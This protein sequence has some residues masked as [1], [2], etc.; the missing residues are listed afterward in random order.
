MVVFADFHQSTGGT[1][2]NELKFLE[3]FVGNADEQA[4]TV[5]KPGGDQGMD[6]F[7]CIREGEGWAEFRNVFDMEKAGFVQMFDVVYEGELWVQLH[8]EIGDCGREGN[9]LTGE[10]DGGYE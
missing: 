2:L 9:V 3:V 10:G 5:I 6:E 8:T 7:F 1:V 4:I